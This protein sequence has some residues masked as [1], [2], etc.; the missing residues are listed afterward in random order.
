MYMYICIYICI[1]LQ[2]LKKRL[3]KNPAGTN[4]FRKRNGI[5]SEHPKLSSFFSFFFQFHFYTVIM[6]TTKK[7][8]GK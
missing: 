8:L 4:K 6:N 7:K 3:T 1:K 5:E 2:I